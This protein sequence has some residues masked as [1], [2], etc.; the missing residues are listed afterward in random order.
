MDV[1]LL[2]RYERD[3]K[4]E[5]DG[6][7]SNGGAIHP[8][9]A[10]E[11]PVLLVLAEEGRALFSLKP[12]KDGLLRITAK[13]GNTGSSVCGGHNGEAFPGGMLVLNVRPLLAVLV[14]PAQCQLSPARLCFR[15]LAAADEGPAGGSNDAGIDSTVD[16]LGYGVALGSRPAA[17]ELELRN[18]KGAAVPVRPGWDLGSWLSLHAEILAPS[19][20]SPQGGSRHHLDRPQKGQSKLPPSPLLWNNRV[21]GGGDAH[22][23]SSSLSSQMMSASK[24]CVEP[25]PPLLGSSAPSSHLQ[26]HAKLSNLKPLCVRSFLP[27]SFLTY[28][29]TYLLTYFLTSLLRSLLS[30]LAFVPCFPSLLSFLAFLPYFPSLLSFSHSF[31]GVLPSFF[32]ALPSF[33]PYFKILGV[34]VIDGDRGRVVLFFEAPA[35][36]YEGTFFPSFHPY[37]STFLTALPSFLPDNSSFL[38]TLPDSPSFLSF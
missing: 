5:E 37:N 7:S 17:L 4:S 11:V 13:C 10:D 3:S 24:T 14:E 32:D 28:L 38:T 27:S 8:C 33:L 9:K 26:K 6:R 30:F 1:Q 16:A 31:L 36:D 22:A 25:L 19:P 18:E 23:P 12:Q 34:R 21:V 2:A 15:D 20:I 35:V 29:L